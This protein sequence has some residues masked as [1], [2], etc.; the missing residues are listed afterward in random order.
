MWRYWALWNDFY[1]ER[2]SCNVARSADSENKNFAKLFIGFLRKICNS[3]FFFLLRKN[4]RKIASDLCVFRHG[5]S[6]EKLLSRARSTIRNRFN[7]FALHARRKKT[8]KNTFKGRRRFIHN[9]RWSLVGRF[10]NETSFIFLVA[11]LL[12]YQQRTEERMT[13]CVMQWCTIIAKG[14]H[15]HCRDYGNT[16]KVNWLIG[17][18]WDEKE[19]KKTCWRQREGW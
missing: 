19:R 10:C 6:S 8:I 17:E 18:C 16:V 9:L 12:A 11:R 14:N 1:G 13:I 15:R 7:S 4:R 2:K 3:F 5:A